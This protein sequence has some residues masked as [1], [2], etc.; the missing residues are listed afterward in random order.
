MSI[1][2]M[3]ELRLLILV[4]KWA[5]IDASGKE[6]IEFKFDNALEFRHGMA[7]RD[8]TTNLSV[9]LLLAALTLVINITQ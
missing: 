6:F 1:A 3:R 2:F 8:M 5:Y 4:K 9:K 7:S